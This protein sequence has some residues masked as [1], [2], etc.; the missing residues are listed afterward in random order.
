MSS[1]MIQSAWAAPAAV[2]FWL[3]RAD[4]TL[5]VRRRAR[6][7]RRRRPRRAR[8]RP[9]ATTPIRKV[10][11]A[12]IV[13]TPSSA[14]LGQVAVGEVAQADRRR[15]G[16]GSRCWPVGGGPQDAGGVEPGRDRQP[17]AR[18]PAARRRRRRARRR[19]GSRPGR[20]TQL[21][22]AVDVAA[23]QRRRGTWPPARA[24]RSAASGVLGEGGRLGD[25]GSAGRRRRPP[26][27]ELLAHLGDVGVGEAGAIG[28][29]TAGRR[30][31]AR[32]AACSPGRWRRLFHAYGVSPVSWVLQLEDP[33]PP[34]LGRVAEAQVEDRQLLLEVGA[35]QHDRGG[36][37]TPR[38][39][40]PGAGREQHRPGRARRR[41]GRRRCR[42]RSRPWP[43]SPRRR[44][45]R[46]CRGRRR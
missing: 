28:Q 42:C 35:E 4:P 3:R 12:T 30:G 24:A 22:G 37:R 21:E 23:A 27:A 44:R 45:P 1:A 7:S 39:S 34:A 33:R 20:Q 9:A 38:R 26:F 11:T 40:W 16:R 14:A 25:R 13:P 36:A 29:A 8:R 32:A 2:T 31:P 15:A 19:P 5:E 41:A 43:A 6:P 46:S 17:T 18:P 10:S